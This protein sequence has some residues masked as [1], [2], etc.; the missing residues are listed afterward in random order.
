MIFTFIWLAINF[1]LCFLNKPVIVQMHSK[2]KMYPFITEA[3]E[4]FSEHSYA[5]Y[6][7]FLDEISKY[8]LS[9]I[10]PCSL[11]GKI[12][13]LKSDHEL[14]IQITSHILPSNLDN[15]KFSL[16][17][18]DRMPK[19]SQQI[20]NVKL[21]HLKVAHDKGISFDCENVFTIEDEIICGWDLFESKLNIFVA[22]DLK[23]NELDDWD[24]IYN[25]SYVN[26]SSPI[27]HYY[28]DIL[29][30]QF[31]MN[32]Q[33]LIQLAQ[34]AKIQY[35]FSLI[36]KKRCD[37]VARLPGY[38][39]VLNIKNTVYMAVDDQK[40]NLYNEP[41]PEILT[42]YR[43]KTQ[44]ENISIYQQIEFDEWE[45][46]F[47][48]S[49]K[50]LS[51][52]EPSS[53]LSKLL[54]SHL[55]SLGESYVFINGQPV[56]DDFSPFQIISLLSKEFTAL[57]ALNDLS[58]EPN[59]CTT[60]LTE[61]I[62]SDKYV[63][64]MDI[65]SPY[66]MW[67]NNIETDSRYKGMSG[68]INQV[69]H[70]TSDLEFD[71]IIEVYRGMDERD[72]I[73]IANPTH[74]ADT[75]LTESN[76]YFKKLGF[77][78]SP[79]VI[80][81]GEILDSDNV[82]IFN[83]FSR[84][85]D[86][87][88]LH[89]PI[90]AYQTFW[91]IL[92]LE[93]EFGINLLT[94]FL[95]T[96]FSHSVRVGIIFSK[97]PSTSN[98]S[99]TDIFTNNILKN[100]NKNLSLLQELV[101][102]QKCGQSCTFDGDLNSSRQNYQFHSFYKKIFDIY[103]EGSYVIH[104][105]GKYGPVTDEYKFTSDDFYIS[106]E[107]HEKMF[108]PLFKGSLKSMI[109]EKSTNSKLGLSEADMLDLVVNTI[110]YKI[111]KNPIQF[112][113]IPSKFQQFSIENN[114]RNNENIF[115]K[116][117][118]FINPIM[119]STQKWAHFLS[120]LYEAVN[121]KLR[122]FMSSDHQMGQQFSNRF[123]RYV[124]DPSIKFIDGKID[125]YS[126]TAIFN[127]L[128]SNIVYTFHA[129]TLQSWF[130]G[131]VFSNCDMDNI[132]L[133]TNELG[134]IGIYELEYIM[135]EGH[136]YNTKQGGP[137][138]GL[139]LVMGT[140]SN[141]E[142]I[143]S[144]T[145]STTDIIAIDSFMGQL[146]KVDVVPINKDNETSEKKSPWWSKISNYFTKSPSSMQTQN[147]S[148]INIFSLATGLLYERFMRIMMLSVL[149]HTKTPVKFWFLKNYV[150]PQFIKS[151]ELLSKRFEFQYEY[152]Q[153][154][155]PH[156]L[157]KQTDKQRII[158]GYK[159]LFLDVLFPLDVKRII[160]VDADQIVR[161]DLNDLYKM[162]L[163][164]APYAY[165]PFCNDRPEME[166]FRF[167]TKGY[168]REHLRGKP[169]HI[170]ALYTVDL[171]KFREMKA[172][173]RLR[174]QYQA[175]YSLLSRDPKSLANLDQDLPNNIQDSVPIKSLPIEWLW[176]ETWCSDKSKSKAKTIDMCNNPLTH[177][178]KLDRAKRIAPEW[179]QYDNIINQ[180]LLNAN[181]TLHEDHEDL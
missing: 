167:W 15:V 106:F 32:H 52:T 72:S 29:H 111:N 92:N 73:L 119:E 155:W 157:L 64:K 108:E 110:S 175:L 150:S 138:S 103:D 94:D 118:A 17:M 89:T 142:I 49:L 82:F 6:W 51:R 139:Q 90:D 47:L 34:S 137:A 43:Y 33:K 61:G 178:S 136:A 105:N 13:F 78:S 50:L 168:W 75:F 16:A 84:R 174:G 173:D 126:N 79:I 149:K 45:D 128:P 179:T 5:T 124:L 91:L 53:R 98:P 100:R 164:E 28:Q 58:F 60:L 56:S 170:S 177:E 122:I 158:W 86:S 18:H 169:Y 38:G 9:S 125:P 132:Y 131:S 39:A 22:N 162:D 23:R 66:I 147:D 41:I 180:I 172:G 54:I 35:V 68:N 109:E 62:S 44:S 76:D 74:S 135:V 30:T 121:I 153:Y 159:I 4:Y 96:E 25:L 160:F 148:H 166:R 133:E 67:L 59:E 99:F 156:W 113:D 55:D 93:N 37:S 8:N 26:K 97:I 120:T 115:I 81:N 2:W 114:P 87:L 71:K 85:R 112:P 10:I 95:N 24:R 36:S 130:F 3:S 116:I 69:F 88:Y 176:C 143:T 141:P 63:Y 57:G 65:R 117:D 77:N 80:F 163:G 102:I 70:H 48:S 181:D 151:I 7:R 101:E 134:C 146:L 165:T 171:E 145:T 11:D 140:V 31:S 12:G 19:E 123:Y 27:V 1:F 104:G 14:A 144:L 152:V 40:I 161:T 154:Q 129:E 46:L 107:I 21:I 83:T 42:S 20:V 127:S